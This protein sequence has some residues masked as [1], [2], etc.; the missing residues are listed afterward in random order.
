MNSFIE[1]K[2]Y[3]ELALDNL[4][5]FKRKPSTKPPGRGDHFCQ[6]GISQRDRQIHPAQCSKRGKSFPAIALEEARRDAYLQCAKRRAKRALD[7]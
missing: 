7:A 1:L 2:L 5:R 3:D 6:G 4:E